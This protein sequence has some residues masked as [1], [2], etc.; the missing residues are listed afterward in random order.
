MIHQNFGV[1]G[2]KAPKKVDPVA[3]ALVGWCDPADWNGRVESVLIWTHM[4]LHDSMMNVRI[5]LT[6]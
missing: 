3:C 2:C 5:L 4:S 1:E 6:T